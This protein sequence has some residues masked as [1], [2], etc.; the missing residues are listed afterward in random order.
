MIASMHA[1]F[2]DEWRTLGE[3]LKEICEAEDDV[4]ELME[5]DFVLIAECLNVLSHAMEEYDVD[6][7]DDTV[8]QLSHYRYSPEDKVVFD[9]M[10]AAVR[11]LDADTVAVCVE[12]IM[13]G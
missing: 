2:L 11:H 5:P 7:A 4:Q 10:A 13:N 12:R 9:E 8:E 1:I 6:V 3:H